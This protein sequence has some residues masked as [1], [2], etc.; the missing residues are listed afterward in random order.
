MAVG[1]NTQLNQGQGGDV[2][3]DIAKGGAKTQVIVLD[4]GGAGTENLLTSGQKTM[5]NS[6]PVA[7]ASD[8]V[9]LLQESLISNANN[10][11]P[12]RSWN[13]ITGRSLATVQN[14]RIDLW[15]GPTANYVFPAAPQQMRV[16]STSANDTAA[17]TGVQ[18]VHIHYLDNLYNYQI[19][20][21]ILNGVTPVNTI[22]TNILR[23]NG[24]HATAV[25]TG[26][27]AAGT[28]SLTNLAGT[29]TYAIIL[30]GYNTARHGIFTVPAGKTGYIAQW[31]GSSGSS[32]GTHFT[33][34][35]IRATCHLGVLFPGVFLFVDGMSGENFSNEASYRIP[36][37]IPAT[38]DVKLSAISDA[39]N[40]N[41]TAIGSIFGWI[42]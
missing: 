28:I 31:Q 6:I 14:T 10:Y 12:A 9:P 13:F 11:Y 35:E 8:Y 29:V 18:Q 37:P 23:I 25:G 5:V 22:P 7:M 17:G 39:A 24:M 26:G 33:Q 41:A 20:T 34:I 40:A 30:A 36:I 32:T 38:A 4:A 42:E 1:D 15:E 3:R 27:N 16:V 19:A 21:V 2:I